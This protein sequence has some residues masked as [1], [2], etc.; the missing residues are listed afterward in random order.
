MEGNK[1]RGKKLTYDK[2]WIMGEADDPIEYAKTLFDSV[3]INPHSYGTPEEGNVEAAVN[4]YAKIKDPKLKERFANAIVQLMSDEEYKKLAIPAASKLHLKEALPGFKNLK[5]LHLD[6]LRKIK[7][8]D[9][10]NALYC[11]SNYANEFY[12]EFKTHLINITDNSKDTFEITHALGIISRKEPD[13]ILSNLEKFLRISFND[14][15]KE[16]NKIDSIVIILSGVFKKYGDSY[17]L[18]L[19]KRFKSS[20]LKEIKLLY[21]KTIS[22]YPT[23]FKP[24]LEELKKIFEIDE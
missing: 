21:Y 11:L 3:D 6:E 24:Y 12:N 10:S 13:F 19:A 22:Q 1:L 17:C 9:D 18:E 7:T 2:N 23:R 5:E 20:L 15:E 4:Q 8:A 14:D 16:Q